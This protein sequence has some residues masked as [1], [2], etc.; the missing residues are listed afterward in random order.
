MFQSAI[1][2]KEIRH[3]E[4][5]YQQRNEY[6]VC[7]SL[8]LQPLIQDIRNWNVS[9]VTDMSKYVC[10]ASILIKTLGSGM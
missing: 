9:K 1:A 6:S 8:N 3:L 7:V 2:F 4:I 10:S 5:G